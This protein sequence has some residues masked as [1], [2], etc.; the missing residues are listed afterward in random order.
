M[1]AI[2]ALGGVATPW[3]DRAAL[4]RIGLYWGYQSALYE[5]HLVFRVSPA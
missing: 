3:R 1:A 2:R 5:R 4:R